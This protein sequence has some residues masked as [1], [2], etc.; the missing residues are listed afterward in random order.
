MFTFRKYEL[1]NKD[2]NTKLLYA[3]ISEIAKTVGVILNFFTSKYSI[4]EPSLGSYEYKKAP[5]QIAKQLYCI[6]NLENLKE[7]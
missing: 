1:K 4:M 2:A 7:K 6:Y 3:I 5:T